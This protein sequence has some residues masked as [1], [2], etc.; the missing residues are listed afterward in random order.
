MN[1]TVEYSSIINVPFEKWF[2]G[3]VWFPYKTHLEEYLLT[4]HKV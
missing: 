3:G 4:M 2:H 1:K